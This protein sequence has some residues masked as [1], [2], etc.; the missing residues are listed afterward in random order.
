M[1]VL[2]NPLWQLLSKVSKEPQNS[3]IRSKCSGYS[4]RLALSPLS[5]KE[6]NKIQQRRQ[7][8]FSQGWFIV[9]VLCISVLPCDQRFIFCM[10]FS[11]YESRSRRLQTNYAKP[12]KREPAARGVFKY[13][14]TKR[15]RKTWGR[16]KSLINTVMFKWGWWFVILWAPVSNWIR[17]YIIQGLFNFISIASVS[18][19]R[20]VF[21]SQKLVGTTP[22]SQPYP[23]SALAR[24]KIPVV[25]I[26][27]R[28][29][30]EETTGKLN[31]LFF[32]SSCKSSSKI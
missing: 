16:T 27:S 30:K 9:N 10:A 18:V 17:N 31:L 20:W 28:S 29:F 12:C 3:N 7:S 1:L 23:V 32:F 5:P 21:V 8:E 15:E 19:E 14:S 26:F 2:V 13:S 24:A 25:I 6:L 11:I 4:A 22:R